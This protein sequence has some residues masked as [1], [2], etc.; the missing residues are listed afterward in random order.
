[1]PAI[2]TFSVDMM[3]FVSGCLNRLPAF[4]RLEVTVLKKTMRVLVHTL[5][6]HKKAVQH[7]QQT[8]VTS[9]GQ[10]RAFYCDHPVVVTGKQRIVTL[11]IALASGEH[12]KLKMRRGEFGL[13]C[14]PFRCQRL[15][16]RS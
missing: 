10:S 11:A 16:R 6:V 1:M 7:R 12:T 8:E 4:R 14:L 3:R 15:G 9:T 5:V 13:Q 2:R